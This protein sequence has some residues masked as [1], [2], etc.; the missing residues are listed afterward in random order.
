[1]KKKAFRVFD[2]CCISCT[3]DIKRL[4]EINTESF[5]LHKERNITIIFHQTVNSWF[6]DDIRGMGIILFQIIKR[7]IFQSFNLVN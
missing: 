4:H 7:E 1:M 3:R 5:G 2:F 6:F